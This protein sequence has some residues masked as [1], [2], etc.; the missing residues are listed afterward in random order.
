MQILDNKIYYFPENWK[1]SR[2]RMYNLIKNYF[3]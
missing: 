2:I 1:V 3:F